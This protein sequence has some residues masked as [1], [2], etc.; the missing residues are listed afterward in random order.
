[1]KAKASA[2]KNNRFIVRPPPYR[3]PEMTGDGRDIVTAIVNDALE[4]V[5]PSARRE[6]D[7]STLC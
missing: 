5:E 7:F 3:S 2:A 6:K 1:M 4:S